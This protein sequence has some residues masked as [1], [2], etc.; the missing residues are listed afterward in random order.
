MRGLLHM[1]Q[2][3]NPFKYGLTAISLI[4]TRL[5]RWLSPVFLFA[6]L[7]TNVFLID[8]PFYLSTF[9]LQIGFYFTAITAFFFERKGYPVGSALSI[10][11]YFCILMGSAIVGLKGLVAGET[12]QMWQTRR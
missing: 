12:G 6:L 3:M 7:I 11:L 2:L 4:S 10:P 8:A 5:L 9:L 1:R